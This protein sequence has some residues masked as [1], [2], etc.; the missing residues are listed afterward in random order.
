[1]VFYDAMERLTESIIPQRS[2]VTGREG[3]V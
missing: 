3:R 2:R 1:M